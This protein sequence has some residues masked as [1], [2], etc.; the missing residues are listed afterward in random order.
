MWPFAF[1]NQIRLL[2]NCSWMPIGSQAWLLAQPQM[3]LPSSWS[4]NPEGRAGG[5]HQNVNWGQNHQLL[6]AFTF[7]NHSSGCSVKTCIANVKPVEHLNSLLV[8]PF[9]LENP[10]SLKHLCRLKIRRLMGLQRLCQPA[11]MEKLPLPAAIRRYLLF[12][13]YDLYGQ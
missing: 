7:R 3:E 12:K 4:W 10:C 6:M 5:L 8:F 11:S 9:L 13:E 2:T 1:E